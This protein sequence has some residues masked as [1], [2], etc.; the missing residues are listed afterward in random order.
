MEL[1]GIFPA[2]ATPRHEDGAPDLEGVRR[3]ARHV[4]DSGVHGVFGA[5][6]TGEGFALSLEEREQVV[7]TIVDEVGEDVPVL[8]GA[9]G[10][11]TRAVIEQ[12]EACASAGADAVCVVTPSF[13]HPSQEEEYEHYRAIAQ[14]SRLPVLVYH[15]PRV[16]HSPLEADTIVRIAG[17]DNVIGMKES[18]GDLA[19]GLSV[20]LRVP[21]DFAFFG[22]QD[23]L[24][25]G[26]LQFGASGA[27]AA[28]GNIAPRVLASLYQAFCRGDLEEAQAAQ[29]K[30]VRVRECL[31]LG[32]PPAAVKEALRLLGLPAGPC[33]SPIAR[34]GGEA[35]ERIAAIL[36]E[37][38]LTE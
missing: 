18:S 34:L 25:L 15:H 35:R 14:A 5:G 31:T 36:R 27:I 17:L 1:K 38:G 33:A 37:V 3:L 16:T 10:D 28:T 6:T 7:G 13:I 20:L 24:I 4:V 21:D 23:S 22:G 19:L 12:C 29:R 8:G 11:C 26:L 2:L 30:I 32:P 9:G